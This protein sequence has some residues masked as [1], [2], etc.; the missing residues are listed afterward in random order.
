MFNRVHNI[1]NCINIA[2]SC[3]QEVDGN[4]L[5]DK[6]TDVLDKVM[7]YESSCIVPNIDD[8]VFDNE[9]DYGKADN[10]ELDIQINRTDVSMRPCLLDLTRT[11]RHD[12]EHV[13]VRKVHQHHT[14]HMQWKRDTMTYILIQVVKMKTTMRA[15]S[16]CEENQTA[17]IST[18]SVYLN[19]L[20][21]NYYF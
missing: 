17:E 9:S 6:I 18:W 13:K 12:W 16:I 11:G 3:E 10:N 21:P 5:Q 2:K 19:E 8:H 15:I 20:Q 1:Y 4:S 14:N 7:D